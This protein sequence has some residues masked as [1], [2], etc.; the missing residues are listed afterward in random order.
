MPFGDKKRGRG[1]SESNPPAAETEPDE[2]VA[3]PDLDVRDIGPPSWEEHNAA[4]RE[5]L[6]ELVRFGLA[7]LF[8]LIFIGTVAY[9]CWAATTKHWPE[10]K[11]LIQILLP[12][13]TALIGSATG[14][15][16]GTRARDGR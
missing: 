9:A 6:Q 1:E 13:E 12:A 8:T 4:R 7:G 15:Y 16:F 2:V 3:G 11:D 10:A 14:F 5:W